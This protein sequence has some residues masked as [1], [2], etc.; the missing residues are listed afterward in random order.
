MIVLKAIIGGAVVASMAASC[1]GLVYVIC[2]FIEDGAK[3]VV[4]LFLLSVFLFGFFA[5]LVQDKP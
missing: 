3:A 4:W 2:A 1:I 5:T